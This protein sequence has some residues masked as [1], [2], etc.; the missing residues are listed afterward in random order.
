MYVG[1]CFRFWILWSPDGIPENRPLDYG[2]DCDSNELMVVIRW[3]DIFWLY[4]IQQ[5]IAWYVSCILT[6]LCGN[7]MFQWL[8]D[9]FYYQSMRAVFH[10]L[11]QSIIWT[12]CDVVTCAVCRLCAFR[13]AFSLSPFSTLFPPPSIF[14]CTSEQECLL[15]LLVISFGSKH[16]NKLLGCFFFFE[17]KL[18][19]IFCSQC[20]VYNLQ[21]MYSC[22]EISIKY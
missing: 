1:C 3:L 4:V 13:S 18:T 15:W 9:A 5:T 7:W 6:F 11:Y 16:W 21:W 8:W 17:W 14:L 22:I 20:R 2:C 12:N 19:W 10:M